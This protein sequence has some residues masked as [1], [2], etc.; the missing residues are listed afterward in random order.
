MFWSLL[1]YPSFWHAINENLVQFNG[2]RK[3]LK[4]VVK[5]SIN[6][7]Y[8]RLCS[9]MFIEFFGSFFILSSQDGENFHCSMFSDQW[10]CEI[11]RWNFV[12]KFRKS[13]SGQ[14]NK[15][16]SGNEVNKF[17]RNYKM[18]KKHI[19]N[20]GIR[21]RENCYRIVATCDMTII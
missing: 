9:F 8:L 15:D 4:N 21:R 16:H 6:T 18:I 11:D 10:C 7:S 14:W 2:R 20:D 17:M 12:W 3:N 19:V 5:L 1:Y 13:F